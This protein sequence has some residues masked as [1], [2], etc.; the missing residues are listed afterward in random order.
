MFD[1]SGSMAGTDMN[2][3]TPHIAKVRDALAA[4]LPNVAPVRNLGLM[5]YG[6]GAGPKCDNI[7]LRL[8]PAANAA[9]RIMGE[10]NAVIPAGQ[11]PLT[12]SVRQAAEALKYRDT[13]AEIVLLTDG[14]ET[15][16]GDPCVLAKALKGAAKNLTI[17][18]IGYRVRNLPAFDSPFT[19]RCLADETGGLYLQAESKDEL[20]AAL[21][22]TLGCPFTT[23]L[24]TSPEH[25]RKDGHICPRRA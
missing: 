5:I 20:I 2:T 9:E 11:T 12:A 19:S 10:V 24:P 16:G 3:V 7:E 1:A 8:K 17:H 13:A 14:E 18:V 4:V 6:P 23:R 15:C 25:D 21:Q 22:K